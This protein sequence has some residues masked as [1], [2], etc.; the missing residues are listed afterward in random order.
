MY[1][2]DHLLNVQIFYFS[3][4]NL[5]HCFIFELWRIIYSMS[6]NLNWDFPYKTAKYSIFYSGKHVFKFSYVKYTAFHIHAGKRVQRYPDV[7][8]TMV[9]LFFLF[10]FYFIFKLYITVL[11]LPNIKMN[12]PQ[13]YMCSPSWTLLP[14]PSPFHP[15]GLSQCTSYYDKNIQLDFQT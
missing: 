11:V 2:D 12:P 1:L 15:S 10:K 5:P 13:V 4:E 3:N 14:P 8:H 6:E 7:K 9:H